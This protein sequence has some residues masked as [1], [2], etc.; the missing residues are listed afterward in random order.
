MNFNI[1]I[2]LLHLCSDTHQGD[3]NLTYP[4]L[5]V[6]TVLTFIKSC[7]ESNKCI[8]KSAEMLPGFN[9]KNTQHRK[10]FNVKLTFQTVLSFILYLTYTCYDIHTYFHNVC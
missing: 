4:V 9:F 6:L 10:F 7:L 8:I 2:L 1:I 3:T 5:S